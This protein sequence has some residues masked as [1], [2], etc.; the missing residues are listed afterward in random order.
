M[1][2][3]H[4]IVTQGVLIVSCISMRRS[5]WGTDVLKDLY[6]DDV[7]LSDLNKPSQDFRAR[8]PKRARSHLS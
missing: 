8:R 4:L 7:F 2:S 1:P 6:I 5:H 3:G